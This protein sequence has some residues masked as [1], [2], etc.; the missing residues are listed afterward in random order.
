M[1]HIMLVFIAKSVAKYLTYHVI[2]ILLS[3]KNNIVWWVDI[4]WGRQVH[5]SKKFYTK[6][7]LSQ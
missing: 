5:N 1:S 7:G 4:I 6:C 3:Y 2:I